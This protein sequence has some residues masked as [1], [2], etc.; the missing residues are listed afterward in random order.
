[1]LLK[2]FVIC[3]DWINNFFFY[4]T[5][6]HYFTNKRCIPL[7]LAAL[8]LTFGHVLYWSHFHS[9]DC[10]SL[11][12]AAQW[13]RTGL[14]APLFFL[15]LVIAT[16]SRYYANFYYVWLATKSVSLRK[17]TFMAIVVKLCKYSVSRYLKKVTYFYKS[18]LLE[19]TLYWVSCSCTKWGRAFRTN[20]L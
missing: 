8:A 6:S 9:I 5:Q 7:L 16:M 11:T 2:N 13:A 3:T 17:C 18:F 14:S 19:C 20:G 15:W 1:M 12:L 4:D 10:P